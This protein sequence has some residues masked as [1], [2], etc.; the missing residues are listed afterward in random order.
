MAFHFRLLENRSG[1]NLAGLLF[2]LVHR[3]RRFLFFPGQARCLFRLRCR[4]K[5][6]GVLGLSHFLL[7]LLFL[8]CGLVHLGRLF[9]RK[10]PGPLDGR[11]HHWLAL[12]HLRNHRRGHFS[13]FH[14]LGHSGL[15]PVLRLS[16][17]NHLVR[18]LHIGRG[19]GNGLPFG[20][21][22]LLGFAHRN[23]DVLPFSAEQPSQYR[24][25]GRSGLLLGHGN[26][27]GRRRRCRLCLF[28]AAG[29]FFLFVLFF[30]GQIPHPLKEHG[31]A[32]VGGYQ[33]T[34][35]P[36]QKDHHNGSCIGEGR[37][38]EHGQPTG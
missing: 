27:G 10:L 34:D 14:R 18:C 32:G 12:R 20:I 24:R 19:D 2:C 17:S 37:R 5:W 16:G 13:A 28:P 33:Q 38:Q 30:R 1:R 25:T 36:C 6:D 23:V 8:G 3:F 11:R 15:R 29:P 4:G 9:G 21:I 35:H 31:K 7:S 26:R 22:W